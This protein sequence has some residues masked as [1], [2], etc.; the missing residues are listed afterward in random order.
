MEGFIAPDK[1]RFIEEFIRVAKRDPKVEFEC[2]LLS[3]QIQTKD[4]AD[5]LM[6]TC[7]LLSVETKDQE[8]YMNVSYRDRTRVT[9]T[10]ATAVHKV[11]MTNSFKGIEN[12]NVERKEPYG[13]KDT[14][15]A[16]EIGARFTLR[17]EI[18]V[19]KDT[20]AKANDPTANIRIITRRSYTSKSGLFQIDI[21]MVKSRK[22]TPQLVRDILKEQHSY[23][24]EI[25]FVKRDT[26]LEETA[27]VADMLGMIEE[28][29]KS[30]YQTQFLLSV[31]DMERY[32]EEFE[33]SG[34]KFYN[35][36]TLE[37]RH[38]REDM[39]HNIMKGYTVTNKADGERCGLYVARDRK[40]LRIIS[41][42]GQ[43]TW[44]GYTAKSQAHFG[45]FVDGEFISGHNLFCIFDVYHYR[46]SDSK[47]LPLMLD[48]DDSTMKNP[49]A[50]RL[51]CGRLFVTDLEKDFT[52]SP[53]STPIRVET[54]MFFAGDDKA[55]ETSIQEMLAMEFEYET[56][57]LIFTPRA[58]RVA[59]PE[60]RLKN[61]WLRVYKWKPASQ[62]SID[63]LLRFSGDEPTFD[64]VLKKHVRAG[65][66][67]VSRSA[68]DIILYPRKTITGE[69][70]APELPEDLRR[71]TQNK[72]R[73][74]SLF[75]PTSPPDPDA[76]RIHIPV[77]DRNVA[78]DQEGTKV[79][80][81]T[82]VECA[83]D[84][85]TSRWVLMRTRY[86]KTY[87]YRVLKAQQY[88]ND[89]RTA[90]S[91]WS[92]IHVPVTKDMIM[93]IVTN[94]IQ[95]TV[96]SDMY[97][98]DDLKRNK[99]VFADVYNF[100]L[101]IKEKL[102]RDNVHAGDT[103]LE[104]AS[105]NGGDLPRWILTKPSKVVAM[106]LSLSNITSP[107]KGAA[108]RYI[109]K[110][111]ASKKGAVPPVLF[112]QGDMAKHPLLDQDDE[113][114][115]ILKGEAIGS[116]PYLK[117]YEGLSTFDV[118]SC[119]FALHYA[120]ESEETFMAFAKN[121]KE[122]CKGRFFGTCSDGK[123]IYTMLF[124]RQTHSFGMRDPK[125]GTY[126]EAGKYT[127]EYTQAGEWEQDAKFGMPV[128]VLLESFEQPQTEYLVPFERVVEIMET[129]G[130]VL[131]DTALF[132]NAYTEQKDTILNEQQQS[133]SFL[134]RT[135]VFRR[136]SEMKEPKE[137]EAVE[138]PV[139][140][141]PPLEQ[142]TE[143]FPEEPA[144]PAPTKPRFKSLTTQLG[145]PAPLPPVAEEP[146][147]PPPPAPEDPK[148]PVKRKL[149][150]APQAPEPEPILFHGPT[151]K[152]DNSQN[153]S[154]ESSHPIMIDDVNYKT[155]EHYVQSQKAKLFND[156]ETY[157]KI[158][159][160]AKT[161]SSAKKFGEDVKG[162]KTE[163]WETKQD[164]IMEIGVRAKFVQ[165]PSLRKQLTET[166]DTVIGDADARD[167]YWGIG[168]SASTEKSKV[169]SKWKGLNKMGKLLMKLRKEFQEAATS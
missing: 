123:Q 28:I 124:D 22:K 133:F 12:L 137:E 23:E 48:S 112:V 168:T 67:F 5:R 65:E 26:K 98:R 47:H 142:D 97:Y 33:K 1:L 84:T 68:G 129:M 41:N 148:K 4:V 19:R 74:P 55:M 20:D 87:Q 110:V 44:T 29:Y 149:K 152:E 136:E 10:G 159:K 70:V 94:P 108:V 120:C 143:N 59:P 56:D 25:E 113:Y 16:S 85:D 9:V 165:H 58:S 13:G 53:T 117:Q 104:L 150:K 11:C 24:L 154:N 126:A 63:F 61:T 93:N 75:Q 121:I 7:E 52:I 119:Q 54:K 95:D 21:S 32:K 3:D 45:D 114:L 80:S 162:F 42:T 83:Y 122:T 147:P 27:I 100:H 40:L 31:S 109:E 157:E 96:D 49:T 111:R 51:G 90:N 62:N 141:L 128:N 134:N 15:D 37:R 69:Y 164:E 153:Y 160:K 34:S 89:I 169:P 127:K 107:T 17:K 155:V 18:H 76:Y 99:R 82:I 36:V 158:L 6:R 35:L 101:Q 103:L 81:N 43:I 64:S 156:D 91:V 73:V 88:G 46:G 38:I 115:K 8:P 102:Y 140:D 131:E 86:D 105:G 77:N 125:T 144:P 14:I 2:K 78:V 145:A 139:D 106:D 116:T 39:P 151:P 66:L 167:F 135:F 138:V 130:F 132:E 79:E 161:A 57:G 30:F 146:A 71:M 72:D 50:S 166:G 163:I 118:V 60:D 92:S